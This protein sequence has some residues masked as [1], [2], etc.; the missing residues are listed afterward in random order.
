MN[1]RLDRPRLRAVIAL[2]LAVVAALVVAACGGSSD[3]TTNTSGSSGGS[4][5]SG[6]SGSKA[7]LNLVGYSTP[8]K[9]YDVLNKAYAATP[10]GKGI[11]F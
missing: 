6:G 1:K 2:G 8:E 3:A 4:G 9:A 5:T 11:A 10:G 7:T